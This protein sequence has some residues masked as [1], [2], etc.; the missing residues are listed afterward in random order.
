MSLRHITIDEFQGKAD[1]SICSIGATVPESFGGIPRSDLLASFIVQHAVH[2]KA[3]VASGLTATG[4][5]SKAARTAIQG[6]TS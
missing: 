2:T 6:A 1:C 5:A 3:G 4:R